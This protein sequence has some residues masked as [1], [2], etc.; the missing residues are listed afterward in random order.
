MTEVIKEEILDLSLKEENF[1]IDEEN[2]MYEFPFVLEDYIYVAMKMYEYDARIPIIRKKLVPNKV[3][4]EQFWKNY[5]YNIE[6]IKLKNNM[7][8]RIQDQKGDVIPVLE[9]KDENHPVDFK[10]SLEDSQSE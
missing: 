8:N 7:Q 1:L 6:V 9:E 2:Y 3:S 5:F 10:I 4:E